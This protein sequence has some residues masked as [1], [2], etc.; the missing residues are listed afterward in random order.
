VLLPRIGI[1]GAALV[2]SV[3]YTVLFAASLALY[4]RAAGL[5]WA[6]IADPTAL[7]D[8]ARALRT[9]RSA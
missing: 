8:T 4:R 1:D 6:Q 2:S 3:A 5:N 7:R 9:P